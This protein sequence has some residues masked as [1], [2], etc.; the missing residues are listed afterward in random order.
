MYVSPNHQIDSEQE[1][2][3]FTED[4]EE[5]DY[6]LPHAERAEAIIKV[7]YWHHRHEEQTTGLDLI[8]KMNHK[9]RA[10]SLNT[11]HD[12]LELITTG[13]KSLLECIQVYF[14][15]ANLLVYGI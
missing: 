11:L 4:M 7:F 5:R 6:D 9:T 1:Y 3:D 15:A 14:N 12:I 13:Q 8:R 10:H 2:K